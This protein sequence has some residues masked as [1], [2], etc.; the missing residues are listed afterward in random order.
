MSKS[1]KQLWNIFGT[2]IIMVAIIWGVFLLDLLPS[3]KYGLVPRTSHGLS[4]ILTAPLIHSGLQHIMSNTIP[5]FVLVSVILFFYKRVALP[6]FFMI[7]LLTGFS[8]WL[9]ARP[10]SHIGASG[11]IY[12]MVSFVFWSGIFRRNIKS[13]VLALVIT[14]M[15]S[16]L[17]Y[18]ILPNEKGVSWESHLFGGII[19][20]FTA[21]FLKD[22][23]E[24]H[25][26][27]EYTSIPEEESTEYLFPKDLFDKTKKEREWEEKYG[28]GV[29]HSDSSW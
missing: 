21:Y 5:M 28:N 12:G 2:P 27:D 3:Y 7:Y 14:V 4:G 25:D 22:I 8:V 29:D 13:I 24:P 26:E 16:G 10:A 6:S 20:I 1:T 19:G 17:F 23:R 9:F 18:G 15:Y 11:V